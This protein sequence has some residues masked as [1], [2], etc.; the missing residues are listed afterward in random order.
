MQRGRALPSDGK[1]KV[2][3]QWGDNCASGL[4][5][6]RV[7]VEGHPATKSQPL[8]GPGV[9]VRGYGRPPLCLLE[10]RSSSCACWNG[11]PMK[12]LDS[13]NLRS[14][15][16]FENNSRVCLARAIATSSENR[17]IE[18]DGAVN[19]LREDDFFSSF[20]LCCKKKNIK[21]A[22]KLVEDAHLANRHDLL[23]RCGRSG[24]P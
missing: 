21:N 13:G 9:S 1:L 6:F 4:S 12:Q 23:S 17:A 20:K 8:T 14:K 15:N 7:V 5:T 2:E 22:L 19:D 11:S 3:S 24:Q 18:D 16:E 10:W